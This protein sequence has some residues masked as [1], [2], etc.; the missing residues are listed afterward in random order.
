MSASPLYTIH[1]YDGYKPCF[2]LEFESL[3]RYKALEHCDML[4]RLRRQVSLDPVH[5]GLAFEALIPARLV[6]SGPEHR[7]LPPFALKGGRFRL[8]IHHG[9]QNEIGY[10]SQVGVADVKEI[11]QSEYLGRVV[12]KFFQA[13]LMQLPVMFSNRSIDYGSPRELAGVEDLVYNALKD[14]QG[15]VIPYY[16]EKHKFLMPN[17]EWARAI[18]KF[19]KAFFSAFPVDVTDDKHVASKQAV[20]ERN[21]QPEDAS[22]FLAACGG[23]GGSCGRSFL[24]DEEK[25]IESLM[26]L[27]LLVGHPY[28]L[29]HIYCHSL[30]Q[31]RYPSGPLFRV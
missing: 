23:I 10:L 1:W 4:K 25:A 21:R 28:S 11:D 27:R 19:C 5:P 31:N 3:D 18:F 8:V 7:P 14:I 17:G 12:R 2:P 26:C 24:A 16:Y 30:S 29:N 9:I 6:P 13:S 20:A 15:L 22:D